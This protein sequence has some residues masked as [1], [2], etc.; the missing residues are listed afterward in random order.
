MAVLAHPDDESLGV[1]GTLAKYASEGGDVFL[2][3]ATLG[4]KGRFR[5]HRPGDL[6]HPGS[7]ELAK[8]RDAGVAGVGV[9]HLP[10]VAPDAVRDRRWRRT[11]GDTAAGLGDNHRHRHERRI[12]CARAS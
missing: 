7:D 8:I 3:T 4:D 2:V 11:A 12:S 1:G 5:G 10:D 6:Q 9:G